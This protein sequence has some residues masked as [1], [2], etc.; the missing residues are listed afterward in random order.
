[1]KIDGV[2]SLLAFPVWRGEGT[3]KISITDSELKPV[4]DE[5]VKHV[6]NIVDPIPRQGAG[7][8]LLAVGMRGIVSTPIWIDININ[9]R[10]V[11]AHGITE[12]QINAPFN[13]ILNQY[14]DELRQNVLT[15]WE[16]TYY[17]NEGIALA[18]VDIRDR[19]LSICAQL[20]N[21]SFATLKN[22]LADKYGQVLDDCDCGCPF[23][24]MALSDDYQGELMALYSQNLCDE[25]MDLATYFPAE[26]AK[27]THIFYTIIHPQVMGV[28]LLNTRLIS[29]LDFAGMQINGMSDPNGFRIE[30][31]QERVF[32]P[33]FNNLDIEIVDYIPDAPVLPPLPGEMVQRYYFSGFDNPVGSVTEFIP[34]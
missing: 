19:F 26:K 13:D 6:Q 8:G 9:I 14:F 21:P 18:Y 15:E 23:C 7:F 28:R 24:Q 25:I 29:A 27:Q 32:M 31:S 5:F 22:A 17:A 3:V 4:S 30:Q 33:R 12:G 11:L 16:R 1:L 20:A 34:D 10:A 2:G